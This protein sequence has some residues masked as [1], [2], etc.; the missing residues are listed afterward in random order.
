[1][2][3]ADFQQFAAPTTQ[4]I[5]VYVCTR[6]YEMEGNIYLARSMKENRRLT[7]LLNSDRR[8]IALTEVVVKDRQSGAIDETVYPYMHV[9]L[10]SIELIKPLIEEDPQT[11]EEFFKD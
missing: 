8:F 6:H 9:N 4:S 1:M 3:N 2:K 11:N 7:N 10:A 5:R